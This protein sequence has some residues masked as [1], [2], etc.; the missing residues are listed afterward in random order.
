MSLGVEDLL[1]L[2]NVAH[3][4]GRPREA[5][6]LLRQVAV[7]KPDMDKGERMLFGLIYKGAV[8]PMRETL[9]VLD[10]ALADEEGSHNAAMVDRI[11]AVRAAVRAELKQ[12]CT[13]AASL[14]ETA[15]LPRAEDSAGRA[16]FEKMRG[17]MFR[18][19]CEFEQ[20]VLE[21]ANSAYTR[22]L[23]IAR[24]DLAQHDP[25]RLRS[26][27]NFA[28]FTFEHLG[29][30]GRAIEMLRQ[31]LSDFEGDTLD[32]AQAIVRVMQ[33]NIESWAG[34]ESTG[35]AFACARER[36]SRTAPHFTGPVAGADLPATWAAR[37]RSDGP[38]RRCAGSEGPR[39]PDTLQWRCPSAANRGR[40]DSD[41][42]A[43]GSPNRGRALLQ[44]RVSPAAAA[45]TRPRAP[46]CSRTVPAASSSHALFLFWRPLRST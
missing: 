24:A 12:C 4:A 9:K 46:V 20:D 41:T 5:I 8:D 16:F 25:V 29:E 10:G 21:Q 33:A 7:L 26:I 40:T 2:A 38:V 15:L 32:E 22:A 39:P 14:V 19:I 18:Y 17:D 1:F 43:G 28:V 27:L 35:K 34:E 44:R 13:D 6:D 3:E 37:A 42:C 36:G 30:N 11:G 23:E 31:A 45:G